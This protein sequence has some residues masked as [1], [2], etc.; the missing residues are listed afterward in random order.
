MQLAAKQQQSSAMFHTSYVLTKT[1]A[2][3]LLLLSFCFIHIRQSL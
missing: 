2:F 3:T 1:K